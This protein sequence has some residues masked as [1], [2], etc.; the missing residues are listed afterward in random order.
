MFIKFATEKDSKKDN[1]VLLTEVVTHE[2]YNARPSF[3]S[4]VDDEALLE[5][6]PCNTGPVDIVV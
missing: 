5:L 3:Y 1:D 2:H 6:T 4:D